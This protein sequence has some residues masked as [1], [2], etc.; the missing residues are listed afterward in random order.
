M[1]MH[2]IVPT[3]ILVGAVFTDLRARSVFNNYLI[4]SA[5][6]VIFNTVFFFG[7]SALTDGL[8]GFGM[9]LIMT[10]PL[11]MA[12][13]LGGGDVK[14]V[15]VLGLGTSYATVMNVTLWSFFWGAFVGLI[16]AVISG[17][18]KKLILNTVNIAR[19]RKPEPT[20]I[21][22]LPF[23]VAIM[24][25]WMTHIVLLQTGGHVW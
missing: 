6:A 12:R 14:L 19:G 20:Q 7:F 22:H 3:L 15:M 10:L 24:L 9:A 2:L 5:I 4:A 23:A 25:A 17:S 21:H 8:L 18:G 16:Y 13:V 1:Q 11:F